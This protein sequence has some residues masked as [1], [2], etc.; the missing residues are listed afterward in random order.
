[1]LEREG[2]TCRYVCAHLCLCVCKGGKEE[3]RR[4]Y[5]EIPSHIFSHQSAEEGA[6]PTMTLP[7]QHKENLLL[8]THSGLLIIITHLRTCACTLY[9]VH[10]HGGK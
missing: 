4:I 1:M 10:E 9:I 2:V 5:I 6:T 7:T 3:Y 8:S